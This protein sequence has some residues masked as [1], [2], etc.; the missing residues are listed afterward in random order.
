MIMQGILRNTIPTRE[1]WLR[2]VPVAVLLA[3]AVLGFRAS[4]VW[5]FIPIG[6]AA[7][8]ILLRQP[9]MGLVGLIVAALAINLPLNTGT[10]VSLNAAAVM[11]PALFA[12]WLLNRMR[13][14][15]IRLVQSRVNLPL[16]LFLLSGIL[17]ILIGNATWSPSVPKSNNFII[18]QFA[19]WAMWAFSA[20]AFWLAGNSVKSVTWLRRLTICYIA[21]A[22]VLAILRVLPNGFDLLYNHVTFAV[23]RAP[24]WLLLTALI[25]GQLFFNRN[26]SRW[27]R[28]AL[29][30]IMVAVLMY[31]F[32]EE[33]ERMANWVSV[34]TVIGVLIW[35]RFPRVRLV[36]IVAV[37]LLTVSGVLFQAIYTFA[38][39]D[40]KWDES[41]GSRLALIGSVVELSMR[42]PITGLGPAAY[43]AYGKTTSL[44][45]GQAFYASAWLS[46]HNNYVDIFS[47]T[48]ILGLGLFFWFMV[49]VFL[50]GIRLR[51]RYPDGFTGGYVHGMIA[52]WVGVMVIMA[53]G[54]WFLPFVYNIGFPGFQAS[55]LVWMFLGGLVALD[56]LKP[57]EVPE[58]AS[59]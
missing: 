24:F 36:T 38:G 29:L 12:V 9:L 46:S 48:G 30:A 43:R 35:L 7:A 17:S 44:Q 55:V 28:I 59:A 19:Q 56:H 8:L 25:V 45:Y 3:A 32:G 15:N 31:S 41:G 16:I 33:Q 47:Q 50:L 23:D 27:Q 40:A 13:D 6:L 14:H 53:I 20:I 54:D 42:N 10:E 58:A 57:A 18:V 26:I 5:L 49:Q 4:P 52:G 22:G 11:V 51:K 1:F 37:L 34:V 2:L 21:V 39:G